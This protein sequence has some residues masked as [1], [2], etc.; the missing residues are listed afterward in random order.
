MINE[1][2][3]RRG[4][5]LVL[6]SPSGTGKT[7]IA[8]KILDSD[9]NFFLSV[10]ATTRAPRPG[11]IDG[12]DYY[13]V[14]RARFDEMVEKG[15]LLEHA[16]FCGNCYGTPRA[17]V[18]KSLSEGRDILFDIEWQ[19]TRQLAKAAR[20]DLVCV[21]I[22][23]PSLAELRRRLVLRKQDSDDAIDKRMATA[24]S[25]DGYR[26]VRSHTGSFSVISPP[27][28]Y[29]GHNPP[30]RS[31]GRVSTAPSSGSTARRRRFRP[32]RG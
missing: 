12:R 3:S 2:I 28:R 14:S 24:E 19:G 1:G 32:N 16:E 26:S 4:L 29:D 15:E 25:G 27:K 17:P 5:M 31:A 10:S 18:E 22:L 23:P 13:F 20:A 30:Y 21:F 7:A 9:P 6:S 11:E 8:H